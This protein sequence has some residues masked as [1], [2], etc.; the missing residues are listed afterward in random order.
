MNMW[1]TI[2]GMVSEAM[3]WITHLWLDSW[4]KQDIFLSSKMSR[5]S[6]GLV[7]DAYSLRTGIQCLCAIGCRVA[8]TIHTR[9]PKARI[10]WSMRM[11]EARNESLFS[12]LRRSM[13][14][15]TRQEGQGGHWE[16]VLLVIYINIKYRIYL[17][18]F[19]I[20]DFHKRY[21]V[22]FFLTFL[23][24]GCDIIRLSC[25]S[26]QNDITKKAGYSSKWLYAGTLCCCCVWI[27]TVTQKH[28]DSRPLLILSGTTSR[29]KYVGIH[30][31]TLVR[32]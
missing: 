11:Q 24:C 16:I 18:V 13:L 15:H 1:G 32:T 27:G 8:S 2:V 21:E 23:I 12:Y 3:D 29:F 26:G 6:L 30:K 14:E 17:Y 28:V 9:I 25:S 5:T 19:W 4:Q 22:Q 10:I 7:P 31:P 20:L